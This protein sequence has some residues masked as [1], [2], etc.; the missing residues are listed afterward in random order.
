MKGYLPLC[1]FVPFV[2][3]KVHGELGISIDEW[4]LL[5]VLRFIEATCKA[6]HV[7]NRNY[8]SRTNLA[9]CERIKKN[10]W[11]LLK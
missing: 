11:K 3:G 10:L 2:G 9:I 8:N 4:I 7:R 5:E 6:T 1:Q